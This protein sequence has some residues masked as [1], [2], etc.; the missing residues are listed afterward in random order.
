MQSLLAEVV[1]SIVA[2][3]VAIAFELI[4]LLVIDD[5]LRRRELVSSLEGVGRLGLGRTGTTLAS[6]L[7]AASRMVL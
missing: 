1:S 3:G 2:H 4:C 6:K 7:Q 5:A